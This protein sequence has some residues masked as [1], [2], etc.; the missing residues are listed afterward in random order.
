[1]YNLDMQIPSNAI[2]TLFEDAV[3]RDLTT[4]RRAAL[5]EILL[6]ERCIRRG[7]LI[8]RV[9]G[10]LGRGCFGES[11]WEDTFYRDMKV[12]KRALRAAGYEPAYSRSADHAGYY[13]RGRSMISEEL[14]K[15]LDG[16]RAE[17]NS[18]QIAILKKLSTKQRFQQGCSITDLACR[19]AAN[20]MMQNNPNLSPI[21]AFRLAV[22]RGN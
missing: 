22:Q 14:S 16:S 20:R 13:L 4:A 11:A 10:K 9:E 21:E 15:I 18:E 7:P 12:V 3:K 17:V 19:T 5:L 2:Q 6:H 1:M 8:V